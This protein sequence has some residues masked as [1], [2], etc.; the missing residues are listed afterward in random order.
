MSLGTRISVVTIYV[1]TTV[2]NINWK[3]VKGNVRNGKRSRRGWIFRAGNQ[4]RFLE[5]LKEELQ[6]HWNKIADGLDKLLEVTC[7]K[8]LKRRGD[9]GSLMAKRKVKREQEEHND[10]KKGRTK[11][12]L[13]YYLI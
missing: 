4:E 6:K 7:E 11:V 13:I 12:N 2:I 3:E 9:M 5:A 8:A 10:R 1:R